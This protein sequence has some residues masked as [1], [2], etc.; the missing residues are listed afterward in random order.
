MGDGPRIL[1]LPNER[2]L[3]WLP[4]PRDLQWALAS[5]EWPLPGWSAAFIRIPEGTQV[6][7]RIL[8]GLV[9]L[10]AHPPLESLAAPPPPALGEADRRLLRLVLRGATDSQAA[11]RLGKSQRWVRYRLA[12]I[13]RLHGESFWPGRRLRRSRSGGQDRK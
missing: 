5:G 7:A 11:A 6:A 3:L 4:A 13:R 8:G 1:F 9:V 2:Q 10:Y 12:N